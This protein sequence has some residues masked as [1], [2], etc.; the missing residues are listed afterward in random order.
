LLTY[1]KIF[2]QENIIQRSI[3]WHRQFHAP[4]QW[5]KNLCNLI[6][7]TDLTAVKFSDKTK[8]TAAAQRVLPQ[9]GTSNHG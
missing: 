5:R 1:C 7:L 9:K 6:K 3:K 4:G 8:K 2:R